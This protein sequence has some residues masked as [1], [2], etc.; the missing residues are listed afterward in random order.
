MH[1]PKLIIP[2]AL[3]WKFTIM[4]II[5]K[6]LHEK[7]LDLQQISEQTGL[8]KETIQNFENRIQ[9]ISTELEKISD[10]LDMPPSDVLGIFLAAPSPNRRRPPDWVCEA[11][12][13]A[14]GCG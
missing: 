4:S 6:L 11:F 10:G 7:D 12:P 1:L 9:E 14:P 3:L 5:Q 13:M 8:S 2:T